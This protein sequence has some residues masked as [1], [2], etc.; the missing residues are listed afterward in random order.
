MQFYRIDHYV[1][2]DTAADPGFSK[3]EIPTQKGGANLLFGQNFLK[4][5]WKLD[6]GHA[7]KILLC[8][9]ATMEVQNNSRPSS[10]EIYFVKY[11]K[12]VYTGES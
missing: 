5:A 8:R 4:T 3:W 9:S 1:R 11:P 6:W 7:S 10:F 2:K 12:A